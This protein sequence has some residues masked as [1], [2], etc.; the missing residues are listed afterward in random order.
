[1]TVAPET[2]D[3][4][5]L[6]RVAD[7]EAVAEWVASGGSGDFVM[8]PRTVTCEHCKT[9]YATESGEVDHA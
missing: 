7:R 9:E 6:P 5:D 3:P 8:A 4:G 2:I 1:V